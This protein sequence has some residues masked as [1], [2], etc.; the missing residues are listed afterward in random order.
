MGDSRRNCGRSKGRHGIDWLRKMKKKMRDRERKRKGLMEREREI[1][2]KRQRAR[3]GERGTGRD[4]RRP[5]MFH[6]CHILMVSVS[7]CWHV[8]PLYNQNAAREH[9]FVWSEG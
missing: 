6:A 5:T 2:R 3:D 4:T 9:T 7:S 1:E 8:W